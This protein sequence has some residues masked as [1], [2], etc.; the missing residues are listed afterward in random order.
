RSPPRVL[1]QASAVGYYGDRG[2]EILTEASPPGRGFLPDTCVAWEA[3]TAPAVERGIRVVALRFGVILSA[4]GGALAKMLPPFRLGLG[5]VV[6]SGRQWWPWLSI[7]DA[8]GLIRHAIAT[9]AVLGA[10]NAVAPEPAT[11]RTF[12]AA[13]GRAVRRP[14]FLPLPA[15]AARVV[16]GEMADALLLSSARVVAGRALEIGFRHRHPTLESALGAALAI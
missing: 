11:N 8:V 13:L 15:F 9:D 12:T 10:V 1:V 16:L 6:G 14:A 4:R 3:A 5:G 2:D 7:D